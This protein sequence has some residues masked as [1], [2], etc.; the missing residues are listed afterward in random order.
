MTPAFQTK[1]PNNIGLAMADMGTMHTS[2][3]SNPQW[4]EGAHTDLT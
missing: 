1:A 3:D 4:Q 2:T